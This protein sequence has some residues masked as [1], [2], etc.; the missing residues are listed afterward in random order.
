MSEGC[1]GASPLRIRQPERGYRFSIDSVILAGFA[2]PFCRG[3]VLDLGTGCGILLLLL[4][5]LS[6]GFVSGTGV[7]LQGDL[8]DFARGNFRDNGPDRRLFAMYGDFRGDIP[9]VEP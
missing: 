4:S 8:L 7:D 9:E 2:A 5:R 3:T 6:P 1:I